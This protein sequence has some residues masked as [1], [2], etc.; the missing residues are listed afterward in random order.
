MELRVTFGLWA[1]ALLYAA[2]RRSARAWPELLAVAGLLCAATVIADLP[3]F[4]LDGV[5]IGT[6][7][8]LLAFAA[9]FGA[10]AAW[11]HARARSATA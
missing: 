11:M 5:S 7:S 2:I 9:A 3:T 8:T 4:A 1:L 10:V 6:D